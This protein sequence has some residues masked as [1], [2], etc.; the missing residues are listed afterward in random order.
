MCYLGEVDHTSS[1]TWRRW[2]IPDVLLGGGESY[3]CITSLTFGL[4][5]PFTCMF[6]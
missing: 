2:I 5:K 4:R 1:V 6:Y 3:L